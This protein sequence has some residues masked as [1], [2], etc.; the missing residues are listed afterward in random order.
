MAP[1][2]ARWWRWFY[3]LI[4]WL[5]L[6]PASATAYELVNV[7]HF[8]LVPAGINAQG[9]PAHRLKLELATGEHVDIRLQPMQWF[10]HVDYHGVQP[11]RQLQVFAGQIVDAADSWARITIEGDAILGLIDTGTQRYEI[12][13]LRRGEVISSVDNG[14]LQRRYSKSY[15]LN[16][17][18]SPVVGKTFERVLPIA[19]VVDELFDQQYFGRGLVQAINIINGVDGIMREELGIAIQLTVAISTVSESFSS[20]PGASPSQLTGFSEFR[21]RVPELQGDIALVH[22]F[23]GSALP[24]FTGAGI[25]YAFIGTV[26]GRNG[27]DVSVSAPYYRGVELAAHEIAHNLGALHDRDTVGCKADMSKLMDLSIDGATQLSTC[28]VDRI[29]ATLQRASCYLEVH[30]GSVVLRPSGEDAVVVAVQSKSSFDTTVSPEVRITHEVPVKHAPVFCRALDSRELSCVLPGVKTNSPYQ[31]YIEF[32]GPGNQTLLAE[33]A[34][35]ASFDNNLRNNTAQATLNGSQS[36]IGPCVDEDGD[37][38]GWNGVASCRPTPSSSANTE[39]P[40][41]TDRRTGQAIFLNSHAWNVGDLVNRTIE[42]RPYAYDRL[43][44]QYL[45]NPAYYT[46]YRHLP[47]SRGSGTGTTEIAKY[48]RGSNQTYLATTIRYEDWTLQVGRYT[49]PAPFARSPHLQIVGAGPGS[50]N[51]I[52][53]FSSE[54][55]FDLCHSFPDPAVPFRPTGIAGSGS[56][57]CRDTAPLN[58]GWGWDGQRSCRVPLSNFALETTS[59]Q[60]TPSIIVNKGDQVV[61]DGLIS[62]AEWSAAT[63]RDN[64]GLA[65]GLPVAIS[66]L[67]SERG[68]D[69]WLIMHDLNFIYIAITVP[70]S[71]PFRDSKLAQHDD[72]VEIFI[73]GGNQRTDRYDTDDT[74]LILRSTGEITGVA[75]PGARFAHVRR[76]DSVQ[77]RYTYEI[78]LSKASLQLTGGEFGIDIQINNDQN[79]GTRDAKWGW[80]GR[81]GSNTHWYRLSDIGIACFDTGPPSSRCQRPVVTPRVCVDTGVVGDGWGWDGARSCRLTSTCIDTGVIGDGWGWN[82]TASCR[83]F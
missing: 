70:D 16:V 67:R 47:F 43:A 27:L 65:L 61:L 36:S 41:Y 71:T 4:V 23:T 28:S 35:G 38:Y 24:T 5:L 18:N 30:D 13:N 51:A 55:S 46:R 57:V 11:G 12:T 7:N 64:D 25:G 60:N 37:G 54:I 50:N 42:C 69:Q 6:V 53:S 74:H 83:L 72:S 66:G 26:C 19:I 21:K 49:G 15:R 58:D 80:S 32:Q 40:E 75:I 2:T 20:L 59:G 34:D 39:I 44:N 76:Y 31:F 1:C 77:Q 45:V 79:G 48:V 73:D 63:T 3:V 10:D 8:S 78:Q 56:P 17:V 68:L 62:A 82:G 22:L 29:E 81:S 33:Y 52:R 14:Q 9:I